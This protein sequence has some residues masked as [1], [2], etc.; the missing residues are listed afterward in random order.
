MPKCG[1]G[2]PLGGGI[3]V[4]GGG[5]DFLAEAF[6]GFGGKLGGNG[7]GELVGMRMRRLAEKTELP[8]IAMTPA[9]EDEMNAQTPPLAPGKGVIQGGGLQPDGGFAVDGQAREPGKR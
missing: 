1:E 9:A 8:A 2:R 3:A 4:L 7:L 6:P 5:P